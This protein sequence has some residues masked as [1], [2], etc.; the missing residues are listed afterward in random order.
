MIQ[1]KLLVEPQILN[2]WGNIKF[3]LL[4]L[5]QKRNFQ[6]NQWDQD[7]HPIGQ[8]PNIQMTGLP[9]TSAKISQ[10]EKSGFAS[11]ITACIRHY[12]II[13]IKSLY[14]LCSDSILRHPSIDFRNM[15]QRMF[16]FIIGGATRSEV[17][18]TC[19]FFLSFCIST[20]VSF[21]LFGVIRPFQ[22]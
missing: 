5:N 2:L 9:G 20:W 13:Y 11:L 1:K 19:N 3:K 15:G 6:H 12:N 7:E 4:L 18:Y 17:K 10:L 22:D 14:L 8:D 21:S 16:V